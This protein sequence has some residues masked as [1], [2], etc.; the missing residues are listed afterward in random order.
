MS[1]TSLLSKFASFA[2]DIVAVPIAA[3][4]LLLT[5]Y[6]TAAAAILDTSNSV[7]SP[8]GISGL[9]D[10]RIAGLQDFS[11]DHLCGPSLVY[12]LTL[13]SSEVEREKIDQ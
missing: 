8:T 12:F 1:V 13:F 6:L 2:S 10:C 7:R 5:L 11:R 4:A 3:A 9:Q